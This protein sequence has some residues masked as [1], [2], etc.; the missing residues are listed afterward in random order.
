[1]RK[2]YTHVFALFLKSVFNG[3][4]SSPVIFGQSLDRFWSAILPR[5]PPCS[6]QP[7]TAP[8]SQA[9]I[10]ACHLMRTEQDLRVWCH[11]YILLRTK[12]RGLKWDY[13]ERHLDALTVLKSEPLQD[14]SLRNQQETEEERQFAE[15]CYFKDLGNL[16]WFYTHGR[17][18][19]R[20]HP[21]FCYRSRGLAQNS[22]QSHMD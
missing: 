4:Y 7:I 18:C 14:I 21:D 8:A 1:M 20:C 10:C 16:G 19:W 3:Q 13:P 12:R 2:K 9:L 15:I 6:R 22:C 17:A 11:I 5:E